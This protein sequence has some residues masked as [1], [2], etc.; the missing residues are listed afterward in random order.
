MPAGLDYQEPTRQLGPDSPVRL[1]V[2]RVA[3][4]AR[5]R[6]TAVHGTDLP[7]TETV[8]SLA[9]AAGALAAVNGTYFDIRTG[10]NHSGYEGDPIGLYAEHGRVLSEAL[11]GRPA[12]VLG[13]DAGR[14]VARVT[15]ASTTGRLRAADGARRELDGVNRVAGRILGCG[16]TG[17][18]RLATTGEVQTEPANGLCTDADEIVSYT[19]QWGARTPP[20]PPGS[21]EALLS[22]SGRVTRLRSPAGGPLPKGGGSLYGIGRGAAWLRVHAAPGRPLAVSERITDADGAS[23]TGP[24]DTALGG[25][26]RLLRDGAVDADAERLGSREPRTVAGVTADGTLLLVVIDG[27][28][29]G[30]SVG[31]T[32]PE[33]AELLSSLGAVDAVNLDG[34]GSTTA[35]VGGALRNSPRATERERVTERP[36]ADA[37]VVL[38]R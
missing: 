30:V 25:S 16:G 20:G 32:G 9:D 23:L 34:G 1:H 33:A 14:L 28:A 10:R 15:E 24:V 27:R 7:N 8:R 12:L 31:A 13:Y 6:V 29:P 26:A 19:P 36:V 35:V 22:S 5:A 3:P 37:L 17:G 21:T 18:D 2:L 38:P 11:S 4:D